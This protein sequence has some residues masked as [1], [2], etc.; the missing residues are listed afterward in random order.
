MFSYNQYFYNVIFM[1]LCLWLNQNI[2]IEAV[3]YG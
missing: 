3:I 1:V 2:S